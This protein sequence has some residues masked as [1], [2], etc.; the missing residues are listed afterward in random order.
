MQTSVSQKKLRAVKKDTVFA[1]STFNDTWSS[2]LDKQGTE[3]TKIESWPAQ[4][5]LGKIIGEI[6]P[7]NKQTSN[8]LKS[9]QWSKTKQKQHSKVSTKHRDITQM[10]QA[11][12][13]QS[14]SESLSD[15]DAS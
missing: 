4:N 6:C 3:N 5:F 1:E 8:T 2:D 11:S 15:F 10:L 9:D 12:R 7:K 13:S 14:D